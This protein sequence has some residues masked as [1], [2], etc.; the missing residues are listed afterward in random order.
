VSPGYTANLA[1]NAI[2]FVCVAAPGHPA[3]AD[4][5]QIIAAS[6]NRR[7]TMVSINQN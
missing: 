2:P 3:T 5:P 6:G 4:L 1:V 7:G